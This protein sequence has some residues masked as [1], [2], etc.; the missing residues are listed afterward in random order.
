MTDLLIRQL[1]FAD[2]NNTFNSAD[3]KDG[4]YDTKLLHDAKCIKRWHKLNNEF[5]E[6]VAL[7][8]SAY[9]GKTSVKFKKLNES[10][11]A[12][13]YTVA[14]SDEEKVQPV[15][16]TFVYALELIKASDQVG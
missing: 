11:E 12:E 3:W 5:D 4:S 16:I 14:N 1:E 2:I 10:S 8:I 15:E 6:H 7:F 13:T 9:V